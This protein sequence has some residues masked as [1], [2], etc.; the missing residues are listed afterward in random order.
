MVSR[1]SSHKNTRGYAAISTDAFSSP[2]SLPIPLVVPPKREMA[3]GRVPLAMRSTAT[4]DKFSVLSYEQ[5][6][7]TLA[8]RRESRIGS[9][10]A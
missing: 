2:H 7:A 9:L 3:I 1:S 5:L 8:H 4:A 10:P 6:V